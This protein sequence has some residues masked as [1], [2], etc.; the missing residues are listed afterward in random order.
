MKILKV[1][2]VNGL[3]LFVVDRFTNKTFTIDLTEWTTEQQ[4]RDALIALIPEP[5][6]TRQLFEDLGLKT[7]EGTDL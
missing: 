2:Y 6:V 4:I 5:D 1:N 3:A 7:W